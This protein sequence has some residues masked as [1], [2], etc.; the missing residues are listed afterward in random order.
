[1][2]PVQAHA[3]AARVEVKRIGGEFAP[4][5]LAQP[6]R[7][8]RLARFAGRPVEAGPDVARERKA[9]LGMAQR[10]PPDDIGGGLR[11]GSI[12]F[13]ELEPRRGGGEEIP[14]LDPRAEARGAGLDRALGPVLDHELEAAGRALGPGA[15]FEPRHR[16]D[17]GQGLAAEAETRDLGQ[18]AVGEFR[19]RV[20]LDA[21]GQIRLVHAAP[22]VGRPG[23][24][25]ARRPRSR[26]RSLLA[27]ASSAF[28]ISSLIA[29][30][31]RSIT[32]P[33]AMRSMVSGSRRRIGMGR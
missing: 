28:S 18:V 20:A 31:G 2:R 25:A 4:E 30:A 15:D 29:A 8:P 1:M 9:G 22:V 6:L 26:P 21:Q 32:S 27:P 33:A 19:G 12:G 10:Q 13:Q 11:L 7:P 16:G 17:R 3:L 5:R 23:S 14:R 24:A